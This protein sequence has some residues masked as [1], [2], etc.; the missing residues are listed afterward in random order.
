MSNWSSFLID[1]LNFTGMTSPRSEKRPKWSIF[2]Q[3]M[4]KLFLHR[5]IQ[6]RFFLEPIYPETKKKILKQSKKVKIINT[7][8][9]IVPAN[10]SYL[11]K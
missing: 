1:Q 9:H 6:N 5:S 8:H 4:T 10:G 11:R 7:Q 2:G 3:N